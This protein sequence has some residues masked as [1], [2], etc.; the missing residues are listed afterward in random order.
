MPAGVAQADAPRNAPPG[1][2][3]TPQQWAHLFAIRA[4]LS[5][6]EAAITETVAVR[7]PLEMRAQWLAELSMLSVDEAVEAVRSM[8]PKAPPKPPAARNGA[9]DRG[10]EGES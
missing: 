7:M 4:R 6:R 3:P 9:K 2:E 8:I 10:K 1:I 5:P